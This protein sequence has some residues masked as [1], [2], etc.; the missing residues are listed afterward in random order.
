M[1]LTCINIQIVYLLYPIIDISLIAVR[2]A[3]SESSYLDDSMPPSQFETNICYKVFKRIWKRP[4]IMTAKCEME[5]SG[6][7][8]Y[9]DGGFAGLPYENQPSV[10]VL[11]E[12]RDLTRIGQNIG[13][14]IADD[15]LTFRPGTIDSTL[16]SK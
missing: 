4:P 13:T 9:H 16:L 14:N 1:P 15:P 10:N 2:K 7:G 5:L 6:G 8:M 3:I 11:A 12:N